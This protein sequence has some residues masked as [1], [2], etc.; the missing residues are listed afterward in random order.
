MAPDSTSIDIYQRTLR[1]RFLL[2]ACRRPLTVLACETQVHRN[3]LSAWVAERDAQNVTVRT[4]R[5][6][7]NWCVEQEAALRT[8]LTVSGSQPFEFSTGSRGLREI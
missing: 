8:W 6:I 2:L 4:L 3:T 5:K 7:E 1:A